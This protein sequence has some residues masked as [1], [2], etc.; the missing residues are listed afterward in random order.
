MQLQISD[1]EIKN[2]QDK[3][4]TWYVENQ[5]DLPWRKTRD[6]YKILV[7]EVMLQQTQVSRVISKYEAWI[8]KFPTAEALAKAEVAEVLK[9]WSG[10]GYNRRALNLKKTAEIIVK[11]FN[12]KFPTDE[13][14]LQSFPGIGPYTSRAV[15]CFAFDVQVAMVDTNIRKIILTQFIKKPVVSEQEIKKL[16]DALLPHGSAYKWNQALMDYAAIML[17]KHKII[18]PKQS[19]FI[20]SH[21]YYRGKIIKLLLENK[22]IKVSE[23][24]KEM[25]KDFDEG[26]LKK[27]LTELKLE[28]FIKIQRDSIVLA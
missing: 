26:Y 22:K 28:G 8:K 20:G 23:I 19:K 14:I 11:D 10:L 3:I 17:K 27:L 7:S 1:K 2:F 12:G 9:F 13:K 18:I 21:R 16:A 5:R 24:E 4:L 25:K 6:P 15:L